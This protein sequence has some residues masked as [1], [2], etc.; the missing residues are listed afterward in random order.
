MKKLFITLLLCCCVFLFGGCSSAPQYSV[1]QNKDGSV[2]QVLFI[3]FYISELQNQGVDNETCL[4][5]S[6]E[7]K[8]YFDKDFLSMYNNF[9]LRVNLD[10]SLTSNDKSILIQGCPSVDE[11]SGTG[12]LN[13][14]VYKLNFDSAIHYY[15]F[16]Y[17]VYYSDL[18]DLLNKDDSIVEQGLFTNKKINKGQT[19][20]GENKQYDEYNTFAEYI[21][22]QCYQILKNNTSLSDESINLIVPSTYVYSYGTSSKRLH[23]DADKI[24]YSN[25]IY[26]HQWEITLENSTREIST[27][28]ITINA[29][30]WYA[31][32]LG[33]GIIFALTL[34]IINKI[35]EKRN[36]KL[37]ETNKKST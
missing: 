32:V 34:L 10:P 30:V 9:I 27:W 36:E 37:N 23:S 7:I 33:V 14:I 26:Y 11:L 1:A 2:E 24:V 12:Q 13:G 6:N 4:I 21:T 25:G 16:N 35:K 31:F 5:L 29:N 3:P 20:F 17:A 22:N 19:I 18:I 8:N 28:R 15:Y